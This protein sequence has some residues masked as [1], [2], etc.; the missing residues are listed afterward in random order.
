M[1]NMRKQG[2]KPSFWLS[3]TKD[4][5]KDTG[6]AMI[7]ICLLFVWIGHKYTLL[8]LAVLILLVTMVWPA[9]LK[10]VAKLWFGFSHILGTVMSKVILSLVFFLVLTPMGV[11]RRIVGKDA[12]QVKT[13]KKGNDSVFRVRDH[14]FDASDIEQPF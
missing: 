2:R 12:M 13:W 5:A 10:P 14:T 7:L 3:P 9:L 8:P 1:D 6:L 11:L 4:Q